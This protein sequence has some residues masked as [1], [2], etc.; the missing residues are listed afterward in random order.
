MTSPLPLDRMR[1]VVVDELGDA[2]VLRARDWPVPDVA[3]GQV[4]IRVTYA[5]VNFVEIMSRRTGYKGVPLPFVPGTEVAG[6]VAAIGAGVTDLQL[7]ARVCALTLTGGYAEFAA[8]DARRVFPVADE[9]PWPQ[10]AAMPTIV[11]TAY[12][13][14]HELGRVRCRDRVLVSAA[15]GASGLVLGQLADAAGAHAVGIVSRPEKVD[16]ARRNGFQE[17]LT[18]SDLERGALAPGSF[19]LVLDSVGGAARAEGWKALAPF[20]TLIAYGNAGGDPEPELTPAQLRDANHNAGG[21]SITALANARPDVL[22]RLARRAFA[23]VADGTVRIPV[24]TVVA[25]DRA[26]DAHRAIESRRTTGK[27]VLAVAD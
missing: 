19:D 16:V 23:L 22:A 1:A 26:A 24:D 4:L 6:T 20:G 21:F 15:A 5:G 13:L 17:V 12:A 9:I 27:T 10:A 2:D 14:L 25:L 18:T 8:V 11:P 7:G 3:P